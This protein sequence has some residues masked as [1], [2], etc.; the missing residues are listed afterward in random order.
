MI[1]AITKKGD[2]SWVTSLTVNRTDV[3][4]EIDTGLA[5]TMVSCL[6]WARDLGKY[7][8]PKARCN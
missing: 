2:G 3:S 6:V 1:Y 4:F 8:C 5:V 7:P